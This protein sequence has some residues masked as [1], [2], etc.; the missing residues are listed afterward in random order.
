VETFEPED[1]TLTPEDAA[2]LSM[3]RSGLGHDGDI[4]SAIAFGIGVYPW[5]T[6]DMELAL[7]DA[8]SASTRVAVRSQTPLRHLRFTT[9]SSTIDLAVESNAGSH[10]IR[11][12]ID[13]PVGCHVRFVAG[14][15]TQVASGDSDDFGHVAIEVPQSGL[16]RIE[17]VPQPRFCTEWFQ[18]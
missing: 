15:G 17:V 6:I 5:R 13:P 18:L 3:L 11:G 4:E 1:D 8:S 16:M 9:E 7:L 12:W 2:L 10:S 14:D